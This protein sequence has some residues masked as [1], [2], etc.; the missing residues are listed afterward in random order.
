[1]YVGKLSVSKALGV[2]IQVGRVFFVV[3]SDRGALYFVKRCN[4]VNDGSKSDDEM[5][6]DDRKTKKRPSRRNKIIVMRD[7]SDGRGGECEKERTRSV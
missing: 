4:R 6:V 1:V 7:E 5:R 3:W 2:K